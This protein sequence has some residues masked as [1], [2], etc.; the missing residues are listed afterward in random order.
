MT[1]LAPS[2]VD[3]HCHSTASDGLLSP[4]GLVAYAAERGVMT[5]GLTDHDSTSGVADAIETGRQHGIKIVPG[6][7]LSAEI[8]SLQAHILGY[9][10]D[11]DSASLQGEFAWMNESRRERV[12][13]IGANLNAA[14][15]TIDATE[16]LALAGNGTVGR[17]HV[18][19]VL[20]ANGYASS[21]SDA[22]DRFLTRGKPGYA[23]SEKITPEGAIGAIN[24]A[25]GV[26]V[27]AHPWSTKNPRAAVERLAPA[28]LTGLECYYGEYT[29]DV[30]SDLAALA[31]E[32]GLIATGGSDFHGKG[33]KST[34]LGGVVVPPEA[35]EA[36]R[37]AADQIRTQAAS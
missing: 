1:T 22:F 14:G 11:P 29:P 7:E 2:S 30:R 10:I 4:A 20:I 15:I 26:A 34:D 35:V 3:L 19:R 16:V 32:F 27:L 36:L 37:A 8:A 13:R 24:R 18:A 28:G 12:E 21:I 33:V 25:G 17:P 9:F 5:I 23:L 6:V 31:A